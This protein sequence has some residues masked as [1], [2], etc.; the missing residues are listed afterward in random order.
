MADQTTENVGVRL[1]GQAMEAAGQL[2]AALE[3]EVKGAASADGVRLKSMLVSQAET[4][5]RLFCLLGNS[6]LESKDLA[7][8][9][10]LLRLGLRAQAQSVLTAKA[11]AELR[12]PQHPSYFDLGTLSDAELLEMCTSSEDGG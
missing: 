7:T 12:P 6:A 11:V 5:N 8:Q 3:G 10:E 9:T 4:L 1:P 2:V